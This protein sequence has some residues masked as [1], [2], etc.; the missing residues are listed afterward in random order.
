MAEPSLKNSGL[1]LRA[2]PYIP[3]E[4]VLKNNGRL[5]PPNFLHETWMDFLYWDTE[6]VKN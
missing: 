3:T 2:Q 5:F 6:L 4:A 1:N